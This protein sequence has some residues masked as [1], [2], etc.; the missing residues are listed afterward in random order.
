METVKT[1]NVETIKIKSGVSNVGKGIILSFAMIFSIT[2]LVLIW[3]NFDWIHGYIGY[4][5]Y[6]YAGLF[7]GIAVLLFVLCLMVFKI[8][9]VVTDRRVVYSGC[10]GHRV[11]LPLDSISAVRRSI[12]NGIAVVTPSCVLRTVFIK[13]ADEVRKEIC[14][15]LIQ[16]QVRKM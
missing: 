12:F 6:C 3:V 5:A 9:I 14:K 4:L 7:L 2:F 10:F 13:D 11:D 16:R 8:Q 1:R 15:L